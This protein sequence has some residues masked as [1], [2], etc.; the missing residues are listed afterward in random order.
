MRE[1]ICLIGKEVENILEEMLIATRRRILRRAGGITHFVAHNPDYQVRFLFDA[2]WLEYYWKTAYLTAEDGTSYPVVFSGDSFLL[3]LIPPG[4]YTLGIT[5][6]DKI[7]SELFPFRVCE[8]PQDKVKEEVDAIP[9][10]AYDRLVGMVNSQVDDVT[11]ALYEAL[12][13]AKDSGEFKGEDGITPHIGANGNWYI[14]DEDTGVF[15]GGGS[16][17]GTYYTI[18]DGLQLDEEGWVLSAEVT[19]RCFQE[20]TDEE[21]QVIVKKIEN[22]E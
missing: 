18:G 11:A 6:G 7:S 3:P 4:R 10:S 13:A 16:G 9:A 17:G 12:Q 20:I 19:P 5:A 2:L 21:F 1:Y 15:S 14:G 22:Q 8:A